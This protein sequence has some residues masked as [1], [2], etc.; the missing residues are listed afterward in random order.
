MCVRCWR[1]F[2][3]ILTAVVAVA[4]FSFAQTKNKAEGSRPV[5]IGFSIDSLKVER[6]QTDLNEFQE[7]AQELGA[8]VQVQDAEGDDE[9]QLAQAKT[10]IDSGIQVLVIVPHNTDSAARIVN[11]AKAKKVRVLA[12][13][14]MISNS[15]VDLF[16]GYDGDTIGALQAGVLT[17]RAA[18]G[19]YVLIGGSP[20]D[21]N[22]RA[23]RAGQMKVLRP[24]LKSGDIKIVADTWAV[25]WDPSDAYVHMVQAIDASQGDITA[26]VASNDGT[27]GGAIQ[28]LGERHLAGKVLVSGQDADLAAIIRILQGTQTMTVYKSLAAQARQA[29]EAAVSLGRGDEIK[30]SRTLNNGAKE[31]PAILLEPVAVTRENVKQTVIKDGFQKL[32]LIKQGLPKEQWPELE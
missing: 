17:A 3:T 13:D 6:W 24:L 8:K 16:V 21:N 10:L 18:K 30:T 12:Y 22:A 26:V 2:P 28:A 29:A 23:F 11:A 5:K 31:V 27:A 20:L 14:R 32:E 4:T 15:D 25:D 7:R 1:A 9:L 19:N